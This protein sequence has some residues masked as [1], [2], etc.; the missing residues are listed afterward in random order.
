MT[1]HGNSAFELVGCYVHSLEKHGLDAGIIAGLDPMNV[2]ATNNIED[3]L[4]MDAD[5]VQYAPLLENVDE[6]FQLLAF[7]K[8]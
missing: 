3:I 1:C 5:I 6:I 2:I 8:M 7:G 4:A